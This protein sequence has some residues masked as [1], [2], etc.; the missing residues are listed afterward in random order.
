MKVLEILSLFW[1][2]GAVMELLPTGEIKLSN[3]E[4][5]S[6]EVTDAAKTVFPQIEKWFKS[7]S[8]ASATQLTLWKAYQQYCGW[9]KNEKILDW[10]NGDDQA[11]YLMNDWMIELG[12]NGWNDIY[13]DYRPYEN[14][15]TNEIA[16]R[17]FKNAVA[18]AK[19]NKSEK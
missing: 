15:Q 7:W 11:A 19:E 8:N 5:I 4:A 9:G 18:Y 3:H 10:L 2:S 17:I 14:E 6:P 13:D 16:N 12:K 1:K